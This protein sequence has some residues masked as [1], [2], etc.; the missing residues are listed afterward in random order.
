MGYTTAVS[1]TFPVPSTTATLQPIGVG[2]YQH[3]CPPKRLD[4]ALNGVVE[5]C[6]NAVGVDVNTAS[7]SLLQ[8]VSGGNSAAASSL[9]EYTEAPASETIM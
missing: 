7:P 6:V 8:R 4:E 3:D 1:S 9:A 2:Q 5:D